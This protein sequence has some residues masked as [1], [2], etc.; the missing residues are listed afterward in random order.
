MLL[1]ARKLKA[2]LPVGATLSRLGSDEFA[3][4]LPS[5]T[6]QQAVELAEA[7]NKVLA[8][9]NRIQGYDIATDASIGIAL[10]LQDYEVGDLLR[11][12]E[13]AMQA[14]KRQGKA[15]H[16]VFDA[17]MQGQLAQKVRL[18]R[19]L[20]QALE[21]EEIKVHYQPLMSLTSGTIIGAEALMRWQHGSLGTIS[22]GAFIPIA[23]DTGMI[24][25][26]SY[27]LLKQAL[28]DLH[29]FPSSFYL[30]VNL[31]VRQLQHPGLVEALSG[32]LQSSHTEPRRLVLEVTESSLMTNPDANIETLAQLSSL[33]FR[34]AM[35]D[36]ATGYSSITYLQRLSL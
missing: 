24:V 9:S 35:D 3:V 10:S 6:E 36:F 8:T 13:S 32:F 23:E 14:A 26:L 28:H 4:F 31:S 2:I 17:Q 1:V 29:E 27:A 20:R 11:D 22:P 7:T 18:E 12:A 16:V 33:G 5:A 30:S 19:D 15:R 21:R 34:L 25:D